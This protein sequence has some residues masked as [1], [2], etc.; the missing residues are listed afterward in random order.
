MDLK[1]NFLPLQRLGKNFNNWLFWLRQINIFKLDCWCHQTTNGQIN[2][3]GF[4]YDAQKSYVIDKFRAEK[5]GYV[6]QTLNLIPF[7]SVFE[8]ISLS[9]KFSKKRAANVNNVKDEVKR[10]LL[11]LGLEEKILAKKTSNLSIGQ[12]Q[13]VAVCRAL[14]GSPKLFLADEPTSAL[15]NESSKKFIKELF[16]TFDKKKQIIIMVSHDLRLA[17]SLI[18]LFT[19]VMFKLFFHLF[20]QDGC[21]LF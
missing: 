10:L 4:N 1:L 8:N 17:D 9:I 11:S 12:Q 3:D 14:L 20:V 5:I 21:Q 15:D 7:L 2:F 16:Q 6:F 19:L 18:E 13:R